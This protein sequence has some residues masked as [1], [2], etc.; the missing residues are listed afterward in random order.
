M[1]RAVL[2][3][4]AL[5]VL[6]A[7]CGGDGASGS[8]GSD[9]SAPTLTI[10]WAE[11]QPSA[12]LQELSAEFTAETGIAVEVK[13]IPWPD[14]QNQV[15][16]EFGNP[17][18][19]FDLVVGDSQWIGYGAERGLYLELTDWMEE[20]VDVDALHPKAAKYLCEY[21]TGS[22]RYYAAPCETDAVGFA[23]RSDWFEDDAERAAFEAEYGRELAPPETWAE[24]RDVAE[25]FTRPDDDRY[26]C[27]LLTGR[28]YDS[29]TM[30]FQNFFWSFGGEW[31]DPETGEVVGHADNAGAVE[32]LKFVKSL[33]AFAPPGA[34][35]FGYGECLENLTNGSVA[36]SMNYFAF[37]PTIVDQ[38]DDR[39][40]FFVVP[41]HDGKRVISL[42]G[43]GLSV[44]AKVPEERQER[45]RRFIAWFSE[46]ATQEKWVAME[47]SFT[48]HAGIL[49]SE[50]FR[51]ATPYNAAFAESLDHLDDFTNLPVFNDLLAVAQK[52]IGEALDG[53]TS[54]QEALTVMAEEQEAILR[55]EGYLE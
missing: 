13:Q 29:L 7:A 52:R 19:A 2:P 39:A 45:A 21:P 35:N 47:A 43:Q 34:T 6:L 28:G 1:I 5:A 14:Y 24:F 26:G 32:G 17:E 11:W 37:Y 20:N 55:D 9:G 41:G 15:F 40:G 23:Y 27:A 8:D 51:G 16:L 12:N 38:L 22:G 53:V 49:A 33:L 30:G 10:W 48:G 36:M 3:A 31:R 18:T 50:E 42:G 44:S 54:A 46:R 25:F 4:A